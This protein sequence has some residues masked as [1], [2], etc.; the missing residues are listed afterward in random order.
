MKV[1]LQLMMNRRIYHLLIIALLILTPFLLSKGLT[2]PLVFDDYPN[3]SPLIQ[4]N[5]SNYFEVIFNNQSGPLGRSVS[6]VS[7]VI[8]DWLAQ[9]MNIYQLKLTGF[10]IH[11]VNTLL[12]YCLS[13][14]LINQTSFSKNKFFLSFVVSS[15]WLLNPI[16]ISTS[17]YVIQRMTTLSFFFVMLGCICFSYLRTHKYLIK[18]TQVFLIFITSLCWILA[19]LSKE[20]GLLLPLYLTILEVCFFKSYSKYFLAITT[21]TRVLLGIILSLISILSIWLLSQHGY[22]NYDDRNFTLLQRIY[23]QPSALIQYISHLLFPISADIGLYSD[24]FKVVKTLSDP[25]ALLNSII[26]CLLFVGSIYGVISSKSLK[27][28]LSGLL[29]FFS[30]HLMESTIFPLELYFEHRNYFPSFGL[31]LFLVISSFKFFQQKNKKTIFFS[32]F[33]SAFV[34]IMLMYLGYLATLSYQVSLAWSSNSNFVVNSYINHPKSVRANL[35]MAQLMVNQNNLELSLQINKDIKSINPDFTFIAQIQRFY[36]YCEL[37]TSIPANEYQEFTRS[38]NLFRAFEVSSALNN[39]L[40][41]FKNNHCDF[42][43]LKQL[44]S[45]LSDWTSRQ[46]TVGRFDA[47]QT[48]AID[49]YAIEF[50]RLQ[51]KE[52]VALER[53]RE[54]EAMGNIKAGQYLQHLKSKR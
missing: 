11:L 9:G 42:I 13:I 49:Y 2:G 32:A 26:I 16:N 27:P 31:Y 8:N 25:V 50:L 40:T 7:F 12:V 4:T 36:S 20:N 24:D 48:W 51:G 23:S 46:I 35:D 17:F 53:L 37:A 22:L 34:F 6:M 18:K 52:S 33:I 15:F 28:A 5:F 30:G 29:L 10:I 47:T 1:V 41:S 43:D 38:I 54:L 19:A 44:G 3:L 21:Q 45:S 14:I 39:L